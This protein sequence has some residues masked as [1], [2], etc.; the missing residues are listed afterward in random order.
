MERYVKYYWTNAIIL[1]SDNVISVIEEKS[2]S[3]GIYAEIFRS[4]VMWHLWLIL[5]WIKEQ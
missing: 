5:K 4:E 1:K 2:L 3:L